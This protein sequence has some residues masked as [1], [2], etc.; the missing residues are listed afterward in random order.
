MLLRDMV[1]V[2]KVF[3]DGVL[4]V[5]VIVVPWKGCQ[6]QSG[7]LLEVA[8]RFSA[9]MAYGLSSASSR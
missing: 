3:I 1:R 7:W 2:R 9:A 5:L 8:C 4:D 6:N